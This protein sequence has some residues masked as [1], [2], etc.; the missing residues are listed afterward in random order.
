MDRQGHDHQVMGMRRLIVALLIVT[1]GLLS[2]PAGLTHA[3]SDAEASNPLAIQARSVTLMDAVTGQVIYGFNERER[4]Q[5]ASLAKIMTFELILEA[6]DQ[7]VFTL[8]TKVPV[9]EKAWRLAL[10]NKLSNMFLEVGDQV[11]VRDLLYGLM[12]SSGNDA[13]VVLAEYRGGSEEG[14]VKMMN[15]RARELGLNET[16]FMNSHGLFAEGQYTTAADV[17][18]LTRHVLQAHPEAVKITGVKE[19]THGK[20]TQPNWNRLVLTDPRVNGLKTGHLPEAGYHLAATAQDRGM[21]LIAVVM[22]TKGEDARAVEARKLLNYGFNN[23]NTVMVDWAPKVSSPLPVYKG[24]ARGVAVAPAGPVAVT[25]P[26]G[27]EKEVAVTIDQPRYAVAPVREGQ[28]LGQ[29]V[30]AVGGQDVVRADLLAQRDVPRA[31]L[32]RS[33]WDSLRLIFRN[34]L[35]R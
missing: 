17:A 14:F 3:Q 20:I 32:L 15:D 9:S 18:T 13:A 1:L 7:G 16:V 22:G 27:R 5:P 34:L 28:K 19:F 10:D 21:S 30:I 25:V 6:L 29:I 11:P 35:G 33:A 26:R 31:G 4:I 24:R 2:F 23:F 12:V 8:D